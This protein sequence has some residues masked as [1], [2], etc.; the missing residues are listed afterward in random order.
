IIVM[1]CFGSCIGGILYFF[2]NNTA[3]K[4]VTN[5]LTLTNTGT[6]ARVAGGAGTGTTTTTTGTTTTTTGTTTTTT[7][8]TV[9][10]D[11][12][13]SL[14][15]QIG[16]NSI[17]A[18]R[19]KPTL[20]PIVQIV[21][22]P[23]QEHFIEGVGLAANLVIFFVLEKMLEQIGYELGIPKVMTMLEPIISKLAP[24]RTLV[25]YLAGKGAQYVAAFVSLGGD[26]GKA[27]LGKTLTG[28]AVRIG[29]FVGEGAAK[30][31]AAAGMLSMGPI[32]VALMAFQ[33]VSMAID[34][35]PA[36]HYNLLGTWKAINQAL[37]DS[38]S[39][40][41][42]DLSNFP[43]RV[44]PIDAMFY[45][46]MPDSN[47]CRDPSLPTIP[48]PTGS[49]P[50]PTFC[51]PYQNSANVGSNNALRHGSQKASGSL[52]QMDLT[53]LMANPNMFTYNLQKNI[54]DVMQ[55]DVE[56]GTLLQNIISSMVAKTLTNAQLDTLIGD[57]IEKK[58]PIWMQ[59]A[60]D[61][62]CVNNNGQIESD[63]TCM[64]NEI[65]CNLPLNPNFKAD[66]IRQWSSSTNRC[67]AV[68]A[69]TKDMCDEKGMK[70]D[71]DKG[72]CVITTA[73]CLKQD[74]NPTPA[75]GQDDD[76]VDECE[77][78]VGTEICG[79]IFG[80]TLCKTLDQLA[81]ANQY[82]PCNAGDTTVSGT[83]YCQKACTDSGYYNV[84]GMCTAPTLLGGSPDTCVNGDELEG[85]I[86]F[87]K[88]KA[89][90]GDTGNYNYLGK[91]SND[92][93]SRATC[94]KDCASYNMSW[95]KG[96][97][98]CK[99]NC[100]SGWSFDGA[101]T[102]TNPKQ[103]YSQNTNYNPSFDMSPC[104][105]LISVTHAVDAIKNSATCTGTTP[106]A[107]NGAAS[108]AA[109]YTYTGWLCD[110]GN[111]SG[112][113]PDQWG[114]HG[115]ATTWSSNTKI[116]GTDP[117]DRKES[118]GTCCEC[119]GN[120]CYNSA[121]SEGCSPYSQLGNLITCDYT[122]K[123][124]CNR[125]CGDVCKSKTGVTCTRTSTA[126]CPAGYVYD[127]VS[128]CNWPTIQTSSHF[129]TMSCNTGDVLIGGMC[130]KACKDGWKMQTAG[131]CEPQGGRTY[132]VK[133]QIPKTYSNSAA[134]MPVCKAG[135]SQ[136]GALC[137]YS[138]CPP[139]TTMVPG[140]QTCTKDGTLNTASIVPETYARKRRVGMA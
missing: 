111:K 27:I 75:D 106:V 34:L 140:T 137:Y 19:P 33:L 125:R 121:N 92:T 50:K 135:T 113:G 109:T 86:C 61:L 18:S 35:S 4:K 51:Y 80:E 6:T 8:T 79:A 116:I 11:A 31:G 25:K 28:F 122:Q 93:I 42:I 83:I 115:G 32:G 60:S 107:P 48:A 14:Q 23:N 70:Y 54:F 72:I 136:Q 98:I 15:A 5:S 57:L 76:P 138:G 91:D 96:A 45:N 56:Y 47:Y 3:S 2:L 9:N 78:S 41:G 69:A 16:H 102:C 139:N 120:Q 68:I 117:C 20:A 130:Y 94:V 65:G 63:G 52:P 133:T 49:Q 103:A 30:V 97:S 108:V 123:A 55:T 101:L 44:S 84:G 21:V 81:K 40:A 77:L 59:Q 82:V 74:G 127:G 66:P 58:M 64:Y 53:D 104:N 26:V 100:S 131:T 124:T 7:G 129:V 89:P 128:M 105:G 87:T 114:N 67:L 22:N 1:C 73:M 90:S 17:E 43:S 13:K 29:E 126:S 99:E 46:Q 36:N 10:D 71:I 134:T 132:T 39:S 118:P 38:L 12:F 119:P 88:C 112:Y 62:M 24:L 37:K 85:G 95:S 110:S